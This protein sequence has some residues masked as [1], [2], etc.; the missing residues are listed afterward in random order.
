MPISPM[1]KSDDT[2]G[3]YATRGAAALFFMGEIGMVMRGDF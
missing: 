1:K 2:S 3:R